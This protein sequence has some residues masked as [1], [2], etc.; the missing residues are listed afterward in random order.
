MYYIRFAKLR[1]LISV[2][3]IE[4]IFCKT[5]SNEISIDLLKV[6]TPLEL[7]KLANILAIHVYAYNLEL[8]IQDFQDGDA[9]PKGGVKILFSKKMK[10]WTLKTCL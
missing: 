10:T 1:S 2:F 4:S 6:I 3:F 8:R 7:L 5:R 9:H